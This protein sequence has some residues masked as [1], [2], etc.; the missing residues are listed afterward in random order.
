MLLPCSAPTRLTSMTTVHI[1]ASASTHPTTTRTWSSRS[2]RRYGDDESSAAWSTSTH[3][4]PDPITRVT[5]Q[6]PRDEYWHRTGSSERSVGDAVWFVGEPDTSLRQ[7][8]LP[9]RRWRRAWPV[10]VSERPGWREYTTA[11]CARCP[12]AG[13]T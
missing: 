4:R 11:V 9:V 12:G 13:G 5:A 7:V 8:G 3:E 6:R 10:H 2:T 1:R